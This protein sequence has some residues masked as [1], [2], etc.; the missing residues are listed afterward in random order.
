[1]MVAR[2]PQTGQSSGVS[3]TMST[4]HL[5]ESTHEASGAPESCWGCVRVC[6]VEVLEVGPFGESQIHGSDAPETNPESTK[7][8]AEPPI[9]QSANLPCHPTRSWPPSVL[10]VLEVPSLV[11]ATMCYIL[12]RLS[13][14]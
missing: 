14:P 3:R 5:V 8:G 13:K 9:C 10:L 12:T 2:L 11:T 6:E 1:M 4:R 7:L